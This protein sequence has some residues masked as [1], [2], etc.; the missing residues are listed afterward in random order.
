MW[1]DTMVIFTT[2]HGYMLGEHDYM[3]KNYMP[4]YNEVFHIP[5]VVWDPRVQNQPARVSGLTQN[6]DMFP[7][8]LSYF[9]VDMGQLHYPI[10][11][12]DLSPMLSGQQASLRD[13][14]IYGYFG[15]SVNYT[16][17]KRTYFRAAATPEN[18]P[19]NVYTAIPTTLRQYYGVTEAGRAHQAALLSLW[20]GFTRGAERLLDGEE[21]PR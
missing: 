13:G 12:K 19:L 18:R 3:A 7:T 4:A 14:V 17:G 8:L 20:R 11:G 6:I 5:L 16:D 21:D 15:K 9:G 2:D 10:H 1:K